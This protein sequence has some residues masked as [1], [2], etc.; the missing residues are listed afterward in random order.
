MLVSHHDD[1]DRHQDFIHA[2]DV[3]YTPV[4]LGKHIKYPFDN[5]FRSSVSV[6]RGVPEHI[7]NVFLVLLVQAYERLCNY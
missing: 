6:V 7:V 2:L 4:Q 1:V 5:L 3:A